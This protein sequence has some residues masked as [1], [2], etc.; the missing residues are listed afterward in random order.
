M[1]EAGI[2]ALRAFAQQS[3]LCL[4]RLLR[5]RRRQVEKGAGVAV[6]RIVGEIGL[7]AAAL[8]AAALRLVRRH[9]DRTDLAAGGGAP[10]GL[11]VDNNT[12]PDAMAD[13]DGG[14]E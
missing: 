10:A 4:G 6:E 7:D 3:H 9:L 5:R 14:R 2:A 12:H 13:H 1:L 11:T 8:A